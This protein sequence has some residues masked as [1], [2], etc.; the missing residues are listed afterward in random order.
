MFPNIP[1]EYTQFVSLILVT[2]GL[3]V[4]LTSSDTLVG[5]ALIGLSCWILMISESALHDK[6][7]KEMSIALEGLRKKQEAEVQDLLSFLRDSQISAQPFDSMDGA[8]RL[9]EHIDYPAM[10]LTSN[11]QIAKANKHMHDAIG[12]KDKAL[13]GVAAHNI[14]VPAVMSRI[15]E[16]MSLPENA[17]RK[18]MVT[19]YVYLHRSGKKVYG[20]M[21]AHEIAPTGSLEGFFVVF[22]PEEQNT[23]S[24][25][26]VKLLSSDKKRISSPV[27]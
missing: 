4:L 17:G 10:V 1:R 13:N 16:I 25:E 15:G 18:S 19:Q 9:C 14:N 6:I 7:Q 21:D 27:S 22:H 20:Q 11:H 3:A 12:W 8:K 23:M 5:V 2:V 26:E 24:N